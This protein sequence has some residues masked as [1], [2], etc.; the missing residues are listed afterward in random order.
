MSFG[1]FYQ[2]GGVLMHAVTFLAIVAAASGIRRIRALRRALARPD[3]AAAVRLGDALAGPLL[4]ALVLCGVLGTAMGTME[5]A[6][7]VAS[8]PANQAFL[9]FMRG[10]SILV[11]PLA[12]SVML[13]IPLVLVHGGL[14]RIE[15]RLSM[16]R[17]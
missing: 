16:R 7:A 15:R 11:I 3:P 4:H 2:S 12:W 6:A 9:A 14:A 13:A 1:Q 5:A 17:A 8:V 10:L